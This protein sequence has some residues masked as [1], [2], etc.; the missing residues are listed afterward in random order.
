MG[1]VI[2]GNFD[3]FINRFSKKGRVKNDLYKQLTD[4]GMKEIRVRDTGK[5]S[6]V[7]LASKNA[8][9]GS[10]DMTLGVDITKGMVQKE[11]EHP[12][13]LS[14]IDKKQHLISKYFIDLNGRITKS[15]TKLK[16]YINGKLNDTKIT[17]DVPNEYKK[18][19]DKSASLE[20]IKLDYNNGNFYHMEKDNILGYKKYHKYFDGSE[21]INVVEKKWDKK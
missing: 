12:M 10:S 18:V 14:I 7:M 16:K 2:L 11:T 13:V 17:T 9:V 1:T 15:I 3:R 19:I 4:K 20:S 6:F 5:D 8:G 21:Y